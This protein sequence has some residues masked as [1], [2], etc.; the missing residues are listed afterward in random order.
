MTHRNRWGDRALELL[1]MLCLIGLTLA[2]IAGGFFAAVLL[3]HHAEING[4]FAAKMP[5]VGALMG[6]IVSGALWRLFLKFYRY[7]PDLKPIPEKK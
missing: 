1:L 7:T 3:S 2:L 4:Y 6:G 5:F